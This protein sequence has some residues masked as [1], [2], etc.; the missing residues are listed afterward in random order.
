[1]NFRGKPELQE[2][3]A[4]EYVLGTLRARASGAGCARTPRSRCSSRAGKSAS[5]RWRRASLR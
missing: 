5:R 2:R 3:L 4:A 1:M